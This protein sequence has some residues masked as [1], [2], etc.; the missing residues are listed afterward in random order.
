MSSTRFYTWHDVEMALRWQVERQAWPDN[1]VSVDVTPT[2]VLIE[3]GEPFSPGSEERVW[4]YLE[5]IF[6]NRLDEASR[7]LLLDDLPGETRALRV[8][9]DFT[10]GVRRLPKPGRP[11]FKSM[12][13]TAE[14]MPG[15]PEG[16]PPLVAFYSFKGGVGRTL[17]LLGLLR[18]LSQRAKTK[19]ILIVDADIE[20]PGL[21]W[22]A[23]KQ[24]GFQD[25]SFLDALA[26]VQGV[27]DWRKQTLP[28]MVEKVRAERLRVPVNGRV[29]EHFFLPAFRADH[30]LIHPPFDPNQLLRAPD[31][32]WVV[33]DVL[34]ELGKRLG[35]SAVLVDLRAGVSELSAPVL[36]DPRVKRVV[37]S[38]TSLQAVRGT[39]FVLQELNRRLPPKS[40]S[41]TPAVLLTMV[42][43]QV[44]RNLIDDIHNTLQATYLDADASGSTADSLFMEEPLDIT[45]IPFAQQ[46][47]HLNDL[48]DIDYKL[49]GAEL[50]FALK[51]V[52][53][54]LVPEAT[55][56]P[57]YRIDQPRAL[58]NRLI[59]FT[60]RFEYAERSETGSFLRTVP[61]RNLARKFAVEAPRAVVMGTKGS[62]KTF[63]YL[64]VA[65]A[66]DW[67]RFASELLTTGSGGSHPI[68]P[69]IRPRFLENPEVIHRVWTETHRI[70]GSGTGLSPEDVG[71]KLE[72][73][74]DAKEAAEGFWRNFWLR[75]LSESAGLPPGAEDPLGAL[76][77]Y[78]ERRNLNLTFIVD[79]LEDWLQNAHSSP[80]AQTAI[81]GLCL[82][83][84]D[85]LSTIP[86]RR[87][88]LVVF[89]RKDL[90]QVSIRQ[91]FGQFEALHDAYELRWNVEEALRLVVWALQEA[92]ISDEVLHD[93][94]HVDPVSLTQSELERS[95]QTLWGLKLGTDMG[96]GAYSAN[97]VLSA[98][99]DF[100]GRLQARDL[101]R[102][103][104][105]SAKHSISTPP[106][107]RK[108]DR[109]LQIGAMKGAIK[110]CGEEKVSQIKQEIP[111]LQDVL[112]R[113]QRAPEGLRKMPFTYETFAIRVSELQ[114]MK[115]Q[116]IVFED[117]GKL[118]TPE[119]Y[120]Q[121]LGLRLE[122][123][124]RP[125]VVTLMRRA[126]A[127]AQR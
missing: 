89:I 29:S 50:E 16:A 40:S 127:A 121:G 58:L 46:L 14:E 62:G 110:P 59:N 56:R 31:R 104:L 125:E 119:I 81:R 22:L 112:D 18:V 92:G 79:G 116:G 12:R 32:K 69:L 53:G 5:S 85:Q 84:F 80:E 30:Q 82:G 101:M 98:L 63:T 20:A 7:L 64:Q 122:K 54:D 3:V 114:M 8:I 38:S 44:D 73:A 83:V 76:Q 103:L 23:R 27:S 97:W 35:V 120:R 72:D 6:P 10:P 102:F 33:T 87:I 55:E 115:N 47:V 43:P 65:R 106:T 68:L 75:M 26:L 15:T 78:L 4:A 52:A 107:A 17:S 24:G 28:L 91:N 100:Q 9:V 1:W 77:E 57:E 67:D 108:A 126:L 123:W 37:V 95:L 11:L 88:G 34:L 118:Y 21:S 19:P 70:L 86:N 113:I 105:H 74:V 41:D 94:A 39:E 117:D 42:P 111:A 61:L 36:F 51:R 90:A 49:S 93:N 25:F 71:R 45:E 109:L 48:D 99:S 124:A 96:K 2:Q 60:R 13:S 66:G